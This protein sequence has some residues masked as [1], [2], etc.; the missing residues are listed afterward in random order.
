MEIRR[1]TSSGST[2]CCRFQGKFKGPPADALDE[3]PSGPYRP[4]LSIIRYCI[5]PPQRG[6]VLREWTRG[7]MPP[8]LK[9]WD[10]QMAN[11]WIRGQL[12]ITEHRILNT[13][14]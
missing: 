5:L 10:L 12:L 1:L 6:H 2:S 14:Y 11:F 4:S 8:R 9:P 7:V 3:I 13:D